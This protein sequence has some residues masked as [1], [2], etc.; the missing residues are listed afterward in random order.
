MATPKQHVPDKEIEAAL[1]SVAQLVNVYGDKYWP[2]FERLEEELE[3]R[4]S[5]SKRLA[6]ALQE[7]N[8]HMK[9]LPRQQFSRWTTN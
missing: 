2:I 4:R 9:C 1:Q 7:R 3:N 5:K 8:Q 6:Q